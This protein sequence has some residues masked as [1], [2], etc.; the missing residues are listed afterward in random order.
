MITPKE[1]A[2]FENDMKDA[3]EETMKQVFNFTVGMPEKAF[4]E[5]ITKRMREL[6]T[7]CENLEYND[8]PIQR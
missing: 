8:R 4:R 7:L 1:L 6:V 5:R 3:Y 2:S